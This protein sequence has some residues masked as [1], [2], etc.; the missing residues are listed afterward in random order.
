MIII[1]V[2]YNLDLKV[3]KNYVNILYIAIIITKCNLTKDINFI[4]H[5]M[6]KLKTKNSKTL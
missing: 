5:K 2:M 6:I 3:I 4:D 1:D